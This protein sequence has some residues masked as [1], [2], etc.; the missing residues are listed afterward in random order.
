[1]DARQWSIGKT[2]PAAQGWISNLATALFAFGFFL[3]TLRLGTF[4]AG[5]ETDPSWSAVLTWAAEHGARFGHQLVFTYGPLGYVHQFASYDPQFYP[6]YIL[7]QVLMGLG[8]TFLYTMTFRVLAPLERLLFVIAILAYAPWLWGDTLMLS[9]GVFAAVALDRCIRESR[10]NAWS[11]AGIVVIALFMNACALMKFSILPTSALL[12][13]LGIVLLLR[14][15]RPFAALGLALIWIC[16]GLALWLGHGQLLTDL[17]GFVRN[18]LLVIGAYGAAMGTDGSLRA[19]LIGVAVLGAALLALLLWLRRE[20]P[21]SLRALLL[22]GYLLFAIYV[23]WRASYTRADDAHT[24]FFIPLMIY[25]VFALCALS[26]PRAGTRLRTAMAVLACIAM[27]VATPLIRHGVHTGH[28]L[29]IV[30]AAAKTLHQLDGKE[31]GNW[32][33]QKREEA[34][35]LHDLPKVRAAIGNERIDLF[36]CAQGIM[37]LNDFNYAPR[38]VFQSYAA[39]SGPLQR[40]NEAYYL[41]ADAPAYVLMKLCPMDLHYPTSDDGLG[42]LALLRRYRPVLAEQGYILLHRDDAARPQPMPAFAGA[43]TRVD[44]GEWL[45]VPAGHDNQMIYLRYQP[46]L[47]GKLRALVLREMVLN[48]EVV[49]SNG[50]AEGFRLVRPVAESGFLLTPFIA[51]EDIYLRWYSGAEKFPVTR[52]RLTVAEPWQ[53]RLFKPDFQIG[54]APVELPDARGAATVPPDL[55]LAVYPGFNIVP[56]VRSGM[57]TVVTEAGSPALFLHAQ[58]TLDF[59]PP[60]GAYALSTAYGLRTAAYESAGCAEASADGVRL[61]VDVLRGGQAMSQLDRNINP[62]RDPTA[63]GTQSS[64]IPRIELA[65]GDRLRLTMGIGEAGNASCDWGYV[66]KFQ[67]TPLAPAPA[68]AP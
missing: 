19:L 45:D 55:L 65:A 58:A 42:L 1:M 53:A 54:F 63:R 21:R 36:G 3:I 48:L 26:T 16:S 60:P 22:S 12:C 40:L 23:F 29:G 9:S 34:R 33:N 51:N 13:G 6:T 44:L 18:S 50:Q 30:H 2:R 4:S 57:I 17:P 24:T 15:R 7:S 56:S 64:E 49:G 20:S 35:K 52:V 68:A 37:M 59:D 46:S 28:Y 11:Y 8:F 43:F 14:D 66:S 61:Q 31:L 39:H 41:S 25:V 32:F 38:P 10:D 67:L 27:V 5:D 62:F 47:L